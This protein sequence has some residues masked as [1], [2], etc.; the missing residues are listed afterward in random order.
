M[1]ITVSLN[2]GTVYIQLIWS[3]HHQP[4][5]EH[6][7]LA[8]VKGMITNHCVFFMIYRNFGCVIYLV[9]YMTVI[10]HLPQSNNDVCIIKERMMVNFLNNEA[11][12]EPIA[13]ES[14]IFY[15]NTSH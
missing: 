5:Y 7:T 3:S 9:I 12:I 1:Q 8:V 14:Y 15:T 4:V 10:F 11:D 6:L 2:T 13:S